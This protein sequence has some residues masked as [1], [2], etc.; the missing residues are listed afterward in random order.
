MSTSEPTPAGGPASR[1]SATGPD[2]E[3]LK[4][5]YKAFKKRL[6]LM[7]LDDESRLTRRS[8]TTGEGSDIV[9][10]QPPAQ[11][12]KA[13]WDALVAE[14]KLRYAGNGL[15]ELPSTRRE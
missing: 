9:S 13:V 12:P 7:R 2:R 5:A 14:G 15:Y 1:P 6:K 11:Y 10:I 4:R 3:T 8:L